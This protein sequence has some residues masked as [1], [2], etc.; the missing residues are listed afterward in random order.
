VLT[1]VFHGYLHVGTSWNFLAV[2]AVVFQVEIQKA[3][4]LTFR[5]AFHFAHYNINV[6]E[7]ESMPYPLHNING[8]FDDKSQTYQATERIHL[9]DFH[10]GRLQ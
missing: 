9:C 6:P 4:L 2:S 10:L 5:I 7:I 1:E 3:A 8:K